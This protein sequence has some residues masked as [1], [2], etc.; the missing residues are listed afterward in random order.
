MWLIENSAEGNHYVL[1]KIAI[2]VA[3]FSETTR[4]N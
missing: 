3:N 2:T 4:N 1:D